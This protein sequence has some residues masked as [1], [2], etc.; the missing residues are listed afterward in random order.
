MLFFDDMLDYAAYVDWELAV[1]KQFERHDFSNVQMIKTAS[2]KFTTSVSF[3]WNHVGDKPEIWGECKLLM[4]KRFVLS[5]Y[6]KVL[7]KKLEHL[8]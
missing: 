6:K 4:R 5:C 3:W 1:D 2:K 8:K 7:L